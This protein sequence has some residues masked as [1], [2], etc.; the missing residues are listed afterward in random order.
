MNEAQRNAKRGAREMQFA[1]RDEA[2]EQ[3]SSMSLRAWFISAPIY[4]KFSFEAFLSTLLLSPL[5]LPEAKPIFFFPPQTHLFFSPPSPI[6]SCGLS[7][8][9]HVNVGVVLRFGEQLFGFRARLF[10]FRKRFFWLWKQ[11][12][13]GMVRFRVGFFL[14]S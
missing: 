7:T 2:A 3:Y 11:N 12:L 5:T 8:N 9:L 6:F 10:G 4:A 13:G 14:C 1:V